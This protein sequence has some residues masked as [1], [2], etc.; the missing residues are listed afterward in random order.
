MAIVN[1]ISHPAPASH[2]SY[3]SHPA[4]VIVVGNAAIDLTLRVDELPRAGETSLA[5]STRFD[6]GGKGANQA[7][8]ASRAGA[9]VALWAA[10][11]NDADGERIVVMLEQE[12]IDIQHLERDTHATDMSIVTVDAYGENTIVTRNEAANAYLPDIDQ[13]EAATRPG[14]WVVLQGNLGEAVTRDVLRHLH[15]GGRHTMLNPGPVRFNCVPML[16]DV[17]VL[18]VNRVEALTLTKQPD[19]EHAAR[20]LCEAGTAHALVTLGSDGVIVCDRDVATRQVAAPRAHAIDTVGAGDALC[21][22][23]VAGLARGSTL[24]AALP[25]AMRVAAYVVEHPGTYSSFPERADMR[26]LTDS[27]QPLQTRTS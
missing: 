23:L 3:P 7:V 26:V 21:G 15:R 2:P 10:V 27:L 17:D 13:L 8:I 12:G 22:A 4:R 6:F 20:M 19:A 16:H 18:V 14:D 1:D 11:G 9:H 24:T 25:A 5:L